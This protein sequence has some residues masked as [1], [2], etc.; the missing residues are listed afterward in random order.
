MAMVDFNMDGQ[1]ELL[2]GSE[3]YEI[4]AFQDDS[5]IAGKR[6]FYSVSNVLYELL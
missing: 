2:V 3:D 6:S 5:L 4:R 1:K